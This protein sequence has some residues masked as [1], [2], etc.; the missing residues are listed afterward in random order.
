MHSE[1]GYI[2][3]AVVVF[4]V[5]QVFRTFKQN[6]RAVTLPKTLQSKLGMSKV[7]DA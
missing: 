4:I 5:P 6:S 2:E 1:F 7:D 3:I